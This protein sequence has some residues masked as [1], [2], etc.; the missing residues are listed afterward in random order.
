MEDFYQY[1][2]EEK[3]QYLTNV[4]LNITD[5][6]NLHCKYCFVKQQPHYMDL[7]VGKDAIDWLA[8]NLQIKKE[9]GWAKNDDKCSVNFFGGEPMLLYEKLIQPLTQ[10]IDENYK[11]LFSLGMTTNGTLLSEEKIN[12]L[13]EHNFYILLSIDGNKETQDSNRPCRDEEKSSFDLVSNNIPYLL[14]V[15]P[16]TTFRATIDE[17][18]AGNTFENYIFAEQAGFKSI[19]MIPNGRTKWKQEN[20]LILEQEVAKIF[21]YR[22]QQ[23]QNGIIPIEASFID[24]AFKQIKLDMKLFNNSQFKINRDQVK[25]V[26]RCGLGTGSGSINFQGDIFGCQEQDSYGEN[27]SIFYLGNIYKNGIEEDL[28]NNL[29]EQYAF[30]GRT[31]CENRKI[32]NQCL[33]RNICDELNCPSTCVDCF[34]D[35]SIMSEIHCIWYNFLFSNS[36]SN[37]IFLLS[38]ENSLFIKYFNNIQIQGG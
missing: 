17:S 21:E 24:K 11:N 14:K 25:R 36:F 23:Y 6:C 34:K 29:L 18:T 32:C 12:W 3:F 16:K 28:H 2:Y 22:K 31:K 8:K 15:Y 9:R 19:F 20:I 10:Y 13:K 35:F 7:Q 5:A 27:N 37:T 30:Q 33:L 38:Q 1:Q 26:T 4:C